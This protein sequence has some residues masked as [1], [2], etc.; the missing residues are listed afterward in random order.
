MFKRFNNNVYT[1]KGPDIQVYGVKDGSVARYFSAPI[2][3]CQD[4]TLMATFNGH[5]LSDR[6]FIFEKPIFWIDNKLRWQK[7]KNWFN[8]RFL[9]RY[10]E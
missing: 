3:L 1:H 4:D 10:S 8:E 6:E 2:T 9:G 5:N 7:I